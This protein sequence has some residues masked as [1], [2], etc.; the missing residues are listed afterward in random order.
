MEET[1]EPKY[2]IQEEQKINTKGG[3][4]RDL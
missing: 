1:K 3:S 2:E 4:D